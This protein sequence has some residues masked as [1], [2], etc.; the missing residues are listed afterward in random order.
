MKRLL[1]PASLVILALCG[2]AC[3]GALKGEDRRQVV[4]PP[5]V[6]APSSAYVGEG[7]HGGST[8]PQDSSND[9]GGVPAGSNAGTGTSPPD[10]I[11]ANKVIIIRKINE[12]CEIEDTNCL[13]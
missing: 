11:P 12:L 1:F 13:F 10:P 8:G 2:G 7:N 9:P 3:G 6:I 5:I 4:M